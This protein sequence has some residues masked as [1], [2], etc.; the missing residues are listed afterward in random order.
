MKRKLDQYSE[1]ETDVED[2]VQNIVPSFRRKVDGKKLPMNIPYTPLDNV[3]FHFESSVQ[4][5]KNICQRRVS[6]EKKLI[7]EDLSGKEIV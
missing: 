6:Q 7:K 1:S 3:S 5:W 4:R 2:D